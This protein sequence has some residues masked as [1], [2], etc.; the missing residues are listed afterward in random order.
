MD[1]FIVHKKLGDF[2]EDL[3]QDVETRSDTWNYEVNRSLPMGKDEQVIGLMKYELNG[4]IMTE[5]AAPG[6][7]MMIC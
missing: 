6:P 4:K 7:K 1:N 5:I 2:Y 3:T